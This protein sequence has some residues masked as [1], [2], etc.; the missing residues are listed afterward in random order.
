MNTM[1]EVT[2]MFAVPDGLTE[3]AEGLARDYMTLAVLCVYDVMPPSEYRDGA[4]ALL[5]KSRD[6]ALAG[7]APESEGGNGD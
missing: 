2:A 6:V 3:E 7:L 4:L 5:L 1:D